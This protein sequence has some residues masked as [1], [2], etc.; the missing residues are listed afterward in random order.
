MNKAELYNSKEI[1]EIFD[2]ISPDEAKRVE[3]R[4]LLA[5][6]IKDAMDA[7]NINKLKFAELMDKHPS[8]ITKWLS[9]THNFTSDTLTDIENKLSIKL[10]NVETQ[11][12]CQVTIFEAFASVSVSDEELSQDSPIL[13]TNY[14]INSSLNLILNSRNLVNAKA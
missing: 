10:L 3:N 8:V 14:F 12:K 7:N 1:D 5:A 4:M 13:D 2:S 9:G 6:K 11:P